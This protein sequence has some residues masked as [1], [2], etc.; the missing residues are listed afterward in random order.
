MECEHCTVALLF[1]VICMIVG[2]PGLWM[3]FYNV[4][5]VNTLLQVVIT[6]C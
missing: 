4:L 3:L 6:F 5:L 1:L 2:Q